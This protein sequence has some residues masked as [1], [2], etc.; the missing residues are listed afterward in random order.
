M[1]GVFFEERGQKRY[2]AFEESIDKSLTCFAM[3]FG[4]D[5]LKLREVIKLYFKDIEKSSNNSEMQNNFN[6]FLI[7]SCHI[8][9]PFSKVLSSHRFSAPEA[10]TYLH[11]I[12]RPYPAPKR[13]PVIFTLKI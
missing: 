1:D 6:G 9:E 7:I 10:W 3:L 12:S 8:T 11:R 2:I 5:Y 13:L 4:S